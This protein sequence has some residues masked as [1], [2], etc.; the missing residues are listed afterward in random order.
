MGGARPSRSRGALTR[1]SL[2]KTL[3]LKW[4]RVFQ[5]K[6]R[7][8]FFFSKKADEVG[9]KG[10]R[11]RHRLCR[12][13]RSS[14]CFSGKRSKGG[15][16]GKDPKGERRASA[17]G[18]EESRDQ[19]FWGIGLQKKLSAAAREGPALPGSARGPSW[20][21]AAALSPRYRLR[22]TGRRTADN[23]PSGNRRPS[24]WADANKSAGLTAPGNCGDRPYFQGP[25]PS[26]EAPGKSER[27]ERPLQRRQPPLSESLQC[28]A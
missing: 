25:F 14:S 18:R 21:A 8:I 13:N 23:W 22:G 9:K 7:S 6:K 11:N 16:E 28:R 2:L 3:P 5:L 15:K 19:R 1:R 20:L 26:P 17:C 27:R 10:I 4:G 24:C 12:G